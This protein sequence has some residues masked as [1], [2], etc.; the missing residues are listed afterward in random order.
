MRLRADQLAAAF[1]VFPERVDGAWVDWDGGGH[2]AP[3]RR[4]AFARWL[5]RQGGYAWHFDDIDAAVE[6]FAMQTNG[7]LVDWYGAVFDSDK[8]VLTFLDAAPRV[9][10]GGLTTWRRLTSGLDSDA[11]ICFVLAKREKDGFGD[12]LEALSALKRWGVFIGARDPQLERLLGRGLADNHVHLEACDPLPIAWLRLLRRE[13]RLQE[14]NRYSDLELQN[15][16]GDEEVARERKRE[17]QWIERALKLDEKHLCH[18]RRLQQ[19]LSADSPIADY[20]GAERRFLVQRWLEVM[21][22]PAGLSRSDYLIRLRAFEG[23]LSAKNAFLAGNQQFSGRGPGLSTFRTYLDSGRSLIEG[24]R[25]SRSRRVLA[26]RLRRLAEFA[27]ECEHTRVIEFRIAP[28]NRAGD[29]VTFFRAWCKNAEPWL[30]RE[31]RKIDIRFVLHFIRRPDLERRSR[32][33]AQFGALRKI[34]DRQSAALHD[35]RHRQPELSRLIIGIDVAN[36]ER[37]CP[38]EIFAP[39]LA[40]LR[41]DRR[42]IDNDEREPDAKADEALDRCWRTLEKLGRAHHSLE[43]PRLCLTYH[44]GED[45]YHPIDGIRQ[46]AGLSDNLLRSGDRIGHG[47]AFGWDLEAFD[48]SRGGEITIPA[49][50]LFDDLVWLRR[51]GVKHG[52]IDASRRYKLDGDIARLCRSIYGRV[53]QVDALDRLLDQRYRLPR[54]PTGGGGEELTASRLHQLETYDAEVHRR[55]VMPA[56]RDLVEA[57]RASRDIAAELQK[58]LIRKL[59]ACGIVVE[60]CPS[61]NLAT[62]AV[63]DLALHPMFRYQECLQGCSLKNG[64]VTQQPLTTINTDDPGVFATRLD[65]EYALML[66]VMERLGVPRGTRFEF[67]ERVRELGHESAFPKPPSARA[68]KHRQGLGERRLRFGNPANPGKS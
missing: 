53:A 32:E 59:S 9:E 23:Y 31:R 8:L 48:A 27:T 30:R 42:L 28:R 12:A 24:K 13:I 50:V 49:G 1:L 56:D 40:R 41:D 58:E 37:Q 4:K 2:D 7:G 34:L 65:I 51:E 19:V 22:R 16:V 36:L 64:G 17:I 61:S 14:V 3:L 43:L 10:L 57:L 63:D 44:C 55:R 68:R 20:L 54:H 33:K 46:M 60:A 15:F 11:L 18:G 25:L 67:L 47:L 21:R 35:F 66:E 29:Y 26:A 45:F 38:P 39:Y 62:G 52:L 5:H 6:S